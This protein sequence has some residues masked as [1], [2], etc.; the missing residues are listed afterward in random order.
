[1][2]LAHVRVDAVVA[3]KPLATLPNPPESRLDRQTQRHV[4]HAH[5]A[6][7]LIYIG[8]ELPI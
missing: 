7:N 2:A 4:L 3:T 5:D 8:V 6:Y 1:M